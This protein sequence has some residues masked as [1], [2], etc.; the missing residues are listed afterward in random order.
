MDLSPILDDDDAGDCYRHQNRAPDAC[1]NFSGAATVIG[2]RRASRGTATR[3]SPN[4]K[5]D[6]IRV[7]MK[8]TKRT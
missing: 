5:V 6:R 3:A 2:I 7:A 8:I 4:P 1:A